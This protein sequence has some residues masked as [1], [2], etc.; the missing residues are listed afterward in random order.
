MPKEL[1]YVYLCF[2]YFRAVERVLTE[3]HLSV[4]SWQGTP[5][6]T[7]LQGKVEGEDG[8]EGHQDSGRCRPKGMDRAEF[9]GDVDCVT[10]SQSFQIQE[11]VLAGLRNDNV[12]S[13][14][15]ESG[16]HVKSFANAVVLV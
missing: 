9:E 5:T 14:Y 10:W 16:G 7:I 15:Y 13:F 1:Y 6:N 12:D 8:E 3:S 2:E 4:S 11:E